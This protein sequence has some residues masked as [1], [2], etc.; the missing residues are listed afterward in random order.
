MINQEYTNEI[1]SSNLSMK[2]NVSSVN[3][4]RCLYGTVVTKLFLSL[5]TTVFANNLIV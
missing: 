5:R 4:D 2:V 3:Y 1:H